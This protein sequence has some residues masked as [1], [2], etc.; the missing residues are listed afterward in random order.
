MAIFSQQPIFCCICGK[1]HTTDFNSYGGIVCSA[2]C[3][4]E[5]GWRKALA[6]L[7][8]EY[9]PDTRKDKE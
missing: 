7:G 1:E 8:E 3:Y 9:T 5:L 2:E 4:T 6:I